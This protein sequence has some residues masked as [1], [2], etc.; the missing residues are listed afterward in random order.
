M[1]EHSSPRD[2]DH[3]KDEPTH[4]VQ[5]TA[6]P[7]EP[8]PHFKPLSAVSSPHRHR[9]CPNDDYPKLNPYIR[10]SITSAQQHLASYNTGT[11]SQQ[12]FYPPLKHERSSRSLDQQPGAGHSSN[13]FSPVTSS[14]Y[15]MNYESTNHMR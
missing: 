8:A 15:D 1:E 5:L 9:A 6:R 14:G 3:P 13:I 12:P 4:S 2:A 7:H 11:T 10:A